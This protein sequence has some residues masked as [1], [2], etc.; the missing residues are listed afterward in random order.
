MFGI[1]RKCFFAQCPLRRSTSANS[2]EANSSMSRITLGEAVSARHPER[3]LSLVSDEDLERL[4]NEQIE[5]VYGKRPA[6][7]QESEVFRWR[8][9]L[10]VSHPDY[11]YEQRAEQDSELHPWP[12]SWRSPPAVLAPTKSSPIV[13][14]TLKAQTN[15]IDADLVVPR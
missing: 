7:P 15:C 4:L 6:S 12:A 9:V 10:N 5:K 3:D 11:T 13:F 1:P 14:R 2:M 8:E